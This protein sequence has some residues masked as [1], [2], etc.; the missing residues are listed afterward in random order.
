M[1]VKTSMTE[2]GRF[3]EK[4]VKAYAKDL[5]RVAYWLSKDRH[6]AEDLVQETFS[7]AWKSIDKL[8]DEHAAKAWLMTILR[9]ENARRFEKKQPEWLEIEDALL[10]G[11]ARYQPTAKMEQ[12]QLY[13]AMMKLDMEFKEPLVMQVIWGFSGEEI[14]RELGLKLA[15][16]NTRLF[17]ARQQ[18][19]QAL[20][21]ND[22]RVENTGERS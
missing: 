18:L 17:R 7:R 19:K 12:Q 5:Y 4:L 11:D 10:E 3:F 15:T 22:E 16:V 21:P 14:A 13:Q 2:P 8:K 1:K 6:V 20:S 9:R